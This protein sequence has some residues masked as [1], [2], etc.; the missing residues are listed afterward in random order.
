MIE[1]NIFYNPPFSYLLNNSDQ[2]EFAKFFIENG[3]N[4]KAKDKFGYTPLGI[5]LRFGNSLNFNSRV[6]NKSQ[7]KGYIKISCVDVSIW[8][9]FDFFGWFN[10][11]L[12]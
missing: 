7:S 10:I 4:V 9:V 11:V 6:G 1:Y 5:A 2:T 12:N 8:H 3:A